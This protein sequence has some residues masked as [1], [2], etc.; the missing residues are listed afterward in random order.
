MVDN[1]WEL[2]EPDDVDDGLELELAD[3]D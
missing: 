1:D 2:D 3:D